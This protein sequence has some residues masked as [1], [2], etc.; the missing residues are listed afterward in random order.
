MLSALSAPDLT[1]V[2]IAVVVGLGSALVTLLCK[3]EGQLEGKSRRP[4]DRNR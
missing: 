4:R 3:V 1:F 2:F